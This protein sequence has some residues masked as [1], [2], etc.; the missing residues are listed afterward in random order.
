MCGGF[1]WPSP[2]S[3]LR[4][5]RMEDLHAELKEAR[6]RL[7]D[8]DA[9]SSDDHLIERLKAQSPF[10]PLIMVRNGCAVVSTMLASLALG[11][12]AVSYTHL[13]LPTICSV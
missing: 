1:L 11:T 10:H 7:A 5:H 6:Q 2:S 4:V 3:C 9:S 13:T 8:F 12:M